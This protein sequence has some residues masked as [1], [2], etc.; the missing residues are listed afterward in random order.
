MHF[1]EVSI[2]LQGWEYK[3]AFIDTPM[4]SNGFDTS[5]WRTN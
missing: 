3:D 5:M 2:T 1:N 4:D